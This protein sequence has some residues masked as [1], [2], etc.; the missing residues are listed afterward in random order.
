M[1]HYREQFS[2]EYDYFKEYKNQQEET[3]HFRHDWKNHMLLLQGLLENGNYDKA[4]EYF[5]TLTAES[6]SSGKR[7]FTG[8]EIVDIIL[9]AKMTKIEEEEIAVSCNGGLEPLSF[10]EDVDVCILFSNLIDNA[11]EANAKCE[12]DRFLTIRVSHKPALFMI[13]VSNSLNGELREKEGYLLSSKED[14]AAHGIGTQNI[15][16]VVRKYA[17][18]Y[19]IRVQDKRFIFTMIFP[20]DRLSQE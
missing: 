17:G 20:L 16:S 18:E 3:A 15:F 1:N 13:E 2:S 12:G 19:S 8:N 5:H 7:I 10:M 14:S 6:I 4:A 11:I 9:S